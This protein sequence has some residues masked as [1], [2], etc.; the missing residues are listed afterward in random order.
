MGRWRNTRPLN[1]LG[2]L[3]TAAMFAAS[4]ALLITF[5]K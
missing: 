2:W 3:S 4:M 1:V 5:M